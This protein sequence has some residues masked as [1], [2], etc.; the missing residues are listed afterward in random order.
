MSKQLDSKIERTE[1]DEQLILGFQAARDKMLKH[2][3]K[4]NWIYCTTL[5]LDP[6]DKLETFDLTPWGLEI[7]SES[8]NRFEKLY[9][10]Y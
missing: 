3:T 6:K 8:L 1:V 10:K 9:D 7:K 4:T 2:Y 5:I